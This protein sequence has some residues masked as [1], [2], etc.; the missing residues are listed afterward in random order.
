[1][2]PDDKRLFDGDDDANLSCGSSLGRSLGKRQAL[3]RA[4]VLFEHISRSASI[5]SRSFFASAIRSLNDIIRNHG[6]KTQPSE[7][8]LEQAH[9]GGKKWKRFQSRISRVE[10]K[11]LFQ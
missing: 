6:A 11:S 2:P 7:S 9:V 5:V 1:M 10:E 8:Q 4:V 3:R